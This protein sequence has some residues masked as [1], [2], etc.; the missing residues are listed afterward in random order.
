MH[1]F[2]HLLRASYAPFF[3]IQTAYDFFQAKKQGE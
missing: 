2:A 1:F 3:P